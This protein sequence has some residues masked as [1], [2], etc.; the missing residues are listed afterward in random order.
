MV[1]AINKHIK[2]SMMVRNGSNGHSCYQLP[3]PPGL[4]Q[5]G[6]FVT[7]CQNNPTAYSPED[8]KVMLLIFYSLYLFIKLHMFRLFWMV[9]GACCSNTLT[10][11]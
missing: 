4:D 9:S 1:L 3:A 11:R 7:K 6:A 2:Q 8:M 10:K 5:L